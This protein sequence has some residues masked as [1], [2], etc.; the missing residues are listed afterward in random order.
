MVGS[1]YCGDHD[2][3]RY[4]ATPSVTSGDMIRDLM[5]K[6]VDVRFGQ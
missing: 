5:V 3:I 4:V 1:R 6:S 2:V